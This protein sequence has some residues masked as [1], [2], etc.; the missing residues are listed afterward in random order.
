MREPGLAYG[1]SCVPFAREDSGIHVPGNAYQWWSNAS[2]HYARGDRPEAGSVLTFRSNDRMRLGHVA[3]VSR[4]INARE[5]IVDHA[6]WPSNGMYGAVS[7]DVAVVDVSE[8]NNW[9]AVRVQLSGSG[10][11]GSVY[12][13]YGFIYNRPDDGLMTASVRPARQPVINQAASGLRP[14]AQRPWQTFEEVAEAP[15][16]HRLHRIG[17]RLPHPVDYK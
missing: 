14:V 6:N 11:F 4:V 2:G 12:P 9:T 13:T 15:A 17:H 10:D 3:V 7:R 1:I 16:P 8:A 5:I